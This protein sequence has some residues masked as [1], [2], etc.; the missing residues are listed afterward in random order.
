MDEVWKPVHGFE[1]DYLISNRGR[2]KHLK[3]N[4]IFKMTNK[5][6]WYFT[7]ILKN[8]TYQ[9]T[10]RVH[11]MV[12]EAFIPNPE[13][14]PF[15]NHI[16]GNKQNNCVENLEWCTQKE[17]AHHAYKNGLSDRNF[18]QKLNKKRREQNYYNNHVCQYTMDGK[19]IKKYVT[20][21]DA[22]RKTGVCSRNIIHCINHQEGRTQAG[23]YKWYK[24]SE[25]VNFEK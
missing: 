4:H 20:A 9:K 7:I 13:N 16:D 1:E 21:A 24:E 23:G 18:L 17:N 12:A 19:F 3:T 8:K 22:S 11:R 2:V 10:C 25:V 6:G 15:V 5:K 14:K